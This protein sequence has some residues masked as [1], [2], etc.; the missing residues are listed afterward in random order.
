MILNANAETAI[1]TVMTIFAVF[2][3]TVLILLFIAVGF[4]LRKQERLE[5]RDHAGH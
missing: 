1:R 4:L 3:V 2:W 5:A